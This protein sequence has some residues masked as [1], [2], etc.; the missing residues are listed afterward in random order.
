MLAVWHEPGLMEHLRSQWRQAASLVGAGELWYRGI[1]VE[2]EQGEGENLLEAC[3][4]G[5]LSTAAA[6]IEHG[7]LHNEHERWWGGYADGQRDRGVGRQWSNGYSTA[8]TY[9]STATSDAWLPISVV[10]TAKLTTKAEWEM[11]GTDTAFLLLAPGDRVEVTKVEAWL[12]DRAT[13]QKLLDDWRGITSEGNFDPPGHWWE[14]D[15]QTLPLTLRTVAASGLP[16]WWIDA[17]GDPSKF[18]VKGGRVRMWRS[19][20]AMLDQGTPEEQVAANIDAMGSIGSWWGSLDTA[21][22]YANED[23]LT[24]EAWL[25]IAKLTRVPGSAGAFLPKGTPIEIVGM[26]RNQHRAPTSIRVFAASWRGLMEGPV[27]TL[28]PAVVLVDNLGRQ[29]TFETYVDGRQIG[30]RYTLVEAKESCEK[31]LG[32]A[33]DWTP[34]R[35]TEQVADHYYFGP[36]A[37]FTDPVQAYLGRPIEGDED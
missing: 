6:I 31:R 4:K 7:L 2:L 35:P 23:I 27:W 12:P 19:I 22:F 36:S 25:P 32:E 13:A 26:I 8:T 1:P 17:V 28:A 29:S 11:D 16:S 21:L 18:E 30:R 9:A 37:E 5:S 34:Y 24:Y 15:R 14:G 3:A 33:L 10:V 20:S